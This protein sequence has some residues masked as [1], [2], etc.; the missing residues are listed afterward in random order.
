MGANACMHG[1]R[2]AGDWHALVEHRAT[3]GGRNQ[4]SAMKAWY[5]GV[6]MALHDLEPVS[7][8]VGFQCALS[9]PFG[10]SHVS[11]QCGVIKVLN[12]LAA[13]HVEEVLA[14]AKVCHLPRPLSA[15]ARANPLQQ[16]TLQLPITSSR[17]C[18]VTLMNTSCTACLSQT[19]SLQ[20]D[21]MQRGH[22]LQR[23]PAAP[24][25]DVGQRQPNGHTA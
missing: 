11:G 24:Q 17:V 3:P 4:N 23:A 6:D 16:S 14:H 5:P 18:R 15:H 1:P 12:E 13:L 25:H 19:H 7:Q 8:R 9:S 2:L 10:G 22:M 20:Q 21:G